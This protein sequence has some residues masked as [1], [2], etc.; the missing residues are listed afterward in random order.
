M[1]QSKVPLEFRVV[2]RDS[3]FGVKLECPS[4]HVEVYVKTGAYMLFNVSHECPQLEARLA[5]DNEVQ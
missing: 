2:G 4:C 1:K 5:A 3:E